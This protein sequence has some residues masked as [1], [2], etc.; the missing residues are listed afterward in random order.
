MRISQLIRLGM[1]TVMAFFIIACTVS[2]TT[3]ST[4]TETTV[5]TMEPTTLTTAPIID[6]VEVLT[7][8]PMIGELLEIGLFE[9]D[10]HRVIDTLYNPY[11][12][13]QI[14][15]KMMFTSPT[16]T[17]LSQLGFWY[18]QYDSIRIVGA[19]TDEFGN[20]VN[21]QETVKWLD[22]GFSHYMVRINPNEVGTWS[23][24]LTVTIN[25][26]IAQSLQGS[27]NVETSE[28][29]SKGYIQVDETNNRTFIFDSGETFTP[30]GLNLAWWQ[31]SLASHDY[32]N[33]FRKLEANNS[34]YARIWLANWS[35][36][37]HK[38]SYSNFETRQSIAIRLDNVFKAAK[39]RG[40]YIMLTLLNHGQF[41]AVTNPEWSENVYN[42]ANGGMLEQP[43]QFF[44]NAEAKA[45]YKNELLYIL[46]R[47][48]YSENIFAWELFNEVDWVDGYSSIAVTNW[49]NEMAKYIHENDPYDHLVTT[50]Y[51][52]TFGTSAYALDSIDFCA[53]HSYAY[54]DVNFYQKLVGEQTAI[55]N[56]YQK[57]VLFGEIGINW[58][59]GSSTY[60][61]DFTG[62]TIKQAAWGGMM[63]G[64]GSANHWWWDSWFENYNMWYRLEGAGAYSNYLDLANK[65][66]TTLQ[67]ADVSISNSS[68]R[69]MGFLLPD[70]IYGYVYNNAWNYWNRLPEALEGVNVEID[71]ANGTYQLLV[72]NTDT[73]EIISDTLVTVLGGKFVLSNLTITEDYAFIL[74]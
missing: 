4:T 10:D 41:S 46:S 70:A 3:Q 26:V 54:S 15:V 56:N 63:S 8:S 67:S 68:A 64:A 42:V 9:P 27:F 72:F 57:P 52:Y 65:T 45:A 33:W 17:T 44:Y 28:T 43:I 30:M 11:D 74:R 22:G 53:V 16:G 47:Y 62:V 39:D 71:F 40:V 34:N 49:H 48:G 7:T 50:S 5:T 36:S 58:Q 1:I 31:T 51:K 21:G 2:T 13:S 23:Y 25:D 12:Y 20:Y 24:V 73:G 38:D 19:V 66:F 14:S 61:T 37:L 32:V 69:I 59:S 6:R 55:W 18:K 35:F 60:H 29:Q